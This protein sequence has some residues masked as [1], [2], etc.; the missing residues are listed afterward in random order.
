[1]YYKPRQSVSAITDC[2]RHMCPSH[3]VTE[4]CLWRSANIRWRLAPIWQRRLCI[5]PVCVCVLEMPLSGKWRTETNPIPMK[6]QPQKPNATNQFL[7]CRKIPILN[8]ILRRTYSRYRY[9]TKKIL[10]SLWSKYQIPSWYWFFLV[11]QIFG[12]RLTSLVCV[13]CCRLYRGDAGSRRVLVPSSAEGHHWHERHD[14]DFRSAR[15]PGG[16]AHHQ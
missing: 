6:W 3:A 8:Q 5:L 13:L 12:Y 16:G 1:M 9:N 15:L 2:R 14:R 4:C 10:R 7:F 11:Y